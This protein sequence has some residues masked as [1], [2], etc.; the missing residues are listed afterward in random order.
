[1]EEYFD[2]AFEGAA[3]IPSTRSYPG[4]GVTTSPTINISMCT[5]FQDVV[6][7]SARH[8]TTDVNAPLVMKLSGA[9]LSRSPWLRVVSVG[10]AVHGGRERMPLEQTSSIPL[11]CV[12]VKT[13]GSL[14]VA[15]RLV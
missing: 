7:S 1:V 15:D 9:G 14:G 6:L 8:I 4:S 11:C 2:R 12:D 3:G 5:V 10:E 13:Q